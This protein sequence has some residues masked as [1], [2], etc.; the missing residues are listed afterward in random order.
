MIDAAP[1]QKF[2]DQLRDIL[3]AKHYSHRTEENYV[4]WVRRYIRFH[5]DKHPQNMAEKEVEAFLT[6][7]AVVEKVSASTQNQ[8]LC[9]LVFT[10]RHLLKQ[11]LSDSIETVRAKR[12]K[13]LPVVLTVSEVRSILAEMDGIPL[14]VAQL[15]YGS[16]LRLREALRLRVKDVDFAQEKIMIRNEK[17]QQDR[18]TLLPRSVV[19]PLKAHLIEVKYLHEK[20]LDA[21]YGQVYL[22]SALEQKHPKADRAWAWQYVFPASCRSTDPRSGLV[23]RH[24]LD[25]TV[26]QKALKT[27]VRQAGITKQASCHTLRHSFATHLLQ[28]GYDIRTVQELLGHKDVKTTMIYTQIVNQGS[29]G[30]R[31]PLDR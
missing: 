31:S 27:A 25:Q 9:A 19:Q 8:A 26:I 7:L 21:G 23:R 11:P 28:N 14:L 10:Y 1:H 3:Q 5:N 24:H 30:V 15:L 16:G 29:L 17:G 6:H 13:H 4:G 22:P 12:P 18:I 2:L 20:D